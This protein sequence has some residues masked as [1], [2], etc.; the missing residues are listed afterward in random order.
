MH[1]LPRLLGAVAMLLLAVRPAAAEPTKID[2]RVIARGA[3]FSGWLYDARAGDADDA[4]TGE[5]L[6]RGVTSG[7]TGDTQGHDWRRDNGGKRADADTAAFRTTLNLDHPRR[8][9]AT[10]TGRSAKRSDDDRDQY[11]MGAARP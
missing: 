9:T 8:I 3:K 1:L 5:I 2:V 6:A 10:V 11:P 7:T 4:D